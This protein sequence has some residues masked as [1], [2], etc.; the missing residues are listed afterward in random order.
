MPD[1]F[2]PITVIAEILFANLDG[3]SDDAYVHSE[4]L[5]TRLGFTKDSSWEKAKV[6]LGKALGL[7][8]GTAGPAEPSLAERVTGA[9]L[10]VGF[11]EQSAAVPIKEPSFAVTDDGH[12][13][14]V[15]LYWA[16]LNSFRSRVLAE[17]AVA[18][19]ATG[20]RVLIEVSG[21]VYVPDPKRARQDSATT[22]G[23]FRP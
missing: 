3:R 21:R 10:D 4:R 17:Y 18:L 13:V 9:L 23:E 5:A 8:D 2:D 1:E 6:A 19:R 12:G 20:F 22:E 14:T 15:S 7:P 11:R 16:A